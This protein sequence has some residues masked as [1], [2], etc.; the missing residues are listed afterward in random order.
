MN[1]KLILSIFTVLVS[2][3]SNQIQAQ[4]YAK[5]FGIE[6]M[7]GINEYGGDRGTRYFYMGSPTYQGGGVNLGYYLTPSFDALLSFDMGEIGHIDGSFEKEGFRASIWSVMPGIRFKFANDKILAKDSKFMPFLQGSWGVVNYVTKI[8]NA[9]DPARPQA[10]FSRFAVQWAVGGGAKYAL[11]PSLDI[12]FQILYNYT[13]DDN[14]DGLPYDPWVHT[15][16]KLMDAYIT[17]RLGLAFNFGTVEGTTYNP[18]KT[19]DEVPKEVK[20]K[21]DM[22]SKQIQFETGKTSILPESFPALDSV[23]YIMLAYPNINAL[24]EGHTDNVGDDEENMLLSQERANSVLNY[25]TDRKVDPSRLSAQGFG[26][27]Q[28][29]KTNNTPEGRALNRRCVVKP[30]IKKN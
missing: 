22:F 14:L 9:P 24:V 13:Y 5:R 23:V 21:L 19:D 12:M 8:R 29:I 6:A 11:T 4:T 27:T 7:G 17:Q 10:S 28:P 2:L 1:K 16:N 26:E 20:L 15:R 18:G 30:F 3:Y 25:L